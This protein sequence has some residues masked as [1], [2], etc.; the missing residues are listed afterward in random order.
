MSALLLF[1]FILAFVLYMK[2][3]TPSGKY[4]RRTQIRMFFAGYVALL[5]LSVGVYVLIPKGEVYPKHELSQHEMDQEIQKF[6]NAVHQGRV[7]DV[8]PSYIKKTWEFDYDNEQIGLVNKYYDTSVVVEKVDAPDK[9]IN[10]VYYSAPAVV[11][12]IN[13]SDQIKP[14]DVILDGNELVVIAPEPVELKLA[15]FRKEF[16]LTQFSEE[17]S[18]NIYHS[19][20]IGNNILYL[21]IPRHIELTH[22][23]N[24]YIQY[25]GE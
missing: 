5:I 6:Y 22:D 3:R 1:I 10:A 17:N 18:K 15:Q 7:D 13:I 2:R 16:T 25:I 24:L 14:I 9:G 20:F 4:V 8:E 19:S 11:G 21:Q 23:P 12:D